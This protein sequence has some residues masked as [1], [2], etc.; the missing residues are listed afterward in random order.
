[1]VRIAEAAGAG[2]ARQRGREDLRRLHASHEAFPYQDIWDP[3]FRIFDAFGFARCM[4]GTDWTR[5]VNVL[6]YRQAV[7]A[8]RVTD[9]LSESDRAAL[10]GGSLQRIYHWPSLA[11]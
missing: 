1:M 10:M 2:G 9:R 4:W 6:T 8:F 3:L 11:E 7:D 5:A